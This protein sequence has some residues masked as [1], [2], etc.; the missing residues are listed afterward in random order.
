MTGR[1]TH[2]LRVVLFGSDV[3]SAVTAAG[4]GYAVR[5]HLAADALPVLGR[6]DV[7]PS[8]YLTALPVAVLLLLLAAVAGGM[9]DDRAAARAP[10]W[11]DAGRVSAFAVATLATV[12]LLY[13]REF[14]YS[15]AVLLAVA[16]MF[17]PLCC[18][19]RRAAITMLRRGYGAR[20]DLPALLIGGGRP[21]I[22]LQRALASESWPPVRFGAVFPVGPDVADASLP[23]LPS[24]VSACDELA[25]GAFG[26]VYVAVPSACATQLP[27]LLTRLEQVAADVRLVPDLGDAVLVNAG[28]AMVGGIPIIS[29]H[30]RPHYGW[31][32]AS[33]RAL[34]AVLALALL[35]VLSPVLVVVALLVMATSPGPVVFIQERMGLDGRAFRMLKFRTMRVGAED[36]SGPVFARPSDPRT[37]RVGRFLRRFSLDELPQLW[38]V[39]L[40]EMSLVGPRPERA[41]FIEEF[42]GRFPGYMLRHTVKAGMTGWAQV[43]GLRGGCSLEDRLRYDLEYVDRWSLSFDIEILARTAYQVVAG[44]NAY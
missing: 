44:R 40:G 13:W 24:I 9:Y 11:A 12:A 39:L 43:H 41:P 7:L 22:A 32:A 19:L 5:F 15:R 10:R 35:V 25:R 8:R 36:A 31:R 20:G 33:K 17:G 27:D 37:T 16:A 30:E 2:Q 3:V 18:G 1:H 28:A 14:Q 34:D 6:T 42:R 23:R 21:A 38:N 4:A 26:D 29:L